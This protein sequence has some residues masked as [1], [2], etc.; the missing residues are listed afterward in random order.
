MRVSV[1]IPCRNA[2]GTVADAVASALGQSSK[3]DEVVVVDDASTDRSVDTA[4]LAGARVIRNGARRNA[5]GARNVGL[6]ATSGDLVA[7]LDADAVAP[8]D[9][10]ARA[11]EILESRTEVVGVGGSVANGRPGRW[12]ALDYYMNHSEWIAGAAGA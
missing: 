9:W 2:A 6:E 5:G 8:P 10:L 7:F 11:R 4:R 1:V 12:G 3:P